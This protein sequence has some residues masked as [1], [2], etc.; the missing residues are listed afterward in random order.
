MML[1][2]KVCVFF[3][4]YNRF[5]AIYR[6]RYRDFRRISEGVLTVIV[7]YSL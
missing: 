6:V 3:L 4:Q 2:I 7:Y 1:K 5:L